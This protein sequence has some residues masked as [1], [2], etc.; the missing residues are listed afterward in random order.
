MILAL[1]ALIAILLIWSA[2]GVGVSV[3][4]LALIIA[5]TRLAAWNSVAMLAEISEIP[6]GDSGRASGVV[7]AGFLLR[8]TIS[9]VLFGLS[10]DRRGEY[11]VGWAAVA[12]MALLIA[13]ARRRKALQSV[14]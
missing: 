5:G 4:W 6:V 8:L 7:L 11:D 9:P 13:A 12:S 14:A 10:V 2:P 1:V 3:F